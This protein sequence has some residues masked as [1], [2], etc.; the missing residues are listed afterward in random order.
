[1]DVTRS[2]TKK[3]R[4]LEVAGYRLRDEFP[5]FTKGRKRVHYSYS[6]FDILVLC[7]IF[8]IQY[9]LDL[10]YISTSLPH[11]LVTFF[12]SLMVISTR[13]IAAFGKSFGY[14]K[15]YS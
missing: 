4:R 12:P 10:R 13:Q 14:T 8:I 1:M 2:Y 6:Q 5:G 7:S 15:N 9:S 11:F 3:I